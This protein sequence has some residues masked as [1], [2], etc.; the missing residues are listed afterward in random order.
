MKVPNE[1]E[2]VFVTVGTTL[3]REDRAVVKGNAVKVNQNKE[4]TFV[5]D[6]TEVIETGS[7]SE[8]LYHSDEEAREQMSDGESGPYGEPYAEYF[9]EVLAYKLDDIQCNLRHSHSTYVDE[10]ADVKGLVTYICI[11]HTK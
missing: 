10:S 9:G 8:T 6:H 5:L 1:G 2:T 11:W 3:P 7:Y 4:G